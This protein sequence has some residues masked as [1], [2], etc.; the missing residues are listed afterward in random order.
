VKNIARILV[1]NVAGIRV[2]I[3]AGILIGSL[4]SYRADIREKKMPLERSTALL[5]SYFVIFTLPSVLSVSLDNP[6][7][8]ESERY[9][10]CLLLPFCHVDDS[11]TDV[12]AELVFLGMIIYQTED[13]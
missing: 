2:E 6:P 13:Y 8:T 4:I 7:C 1:R 11:L 5:K 10:C 9:R 12:L 3:V